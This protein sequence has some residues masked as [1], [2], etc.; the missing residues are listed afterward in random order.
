MCTVISSQNAILISLPTPLKSCVKLSVLR[1]TWS[2]AGRRTLL[3]EQ[4]FYCLQ[5]CD[6]Y[7]RFNGNNHH[8]VLALTGM[9]RS[10]ENMIKQDNTSY[11]FTI[12]LVLMYS[13]VTVYVSV[14]N[15]TIYPD[16]KDNSS[17]TPTLLPC[18]WWLSMPEVV[19]INRT[20]YC[21]F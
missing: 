3:S 11:S 7:Y 18:G 6:L 14:L 16:P 19:L 15:D 10:Y 17:W 4:Q 20:Y 9:I 21:R 13:L 5:M 8:P 2:S 1:C 12:M